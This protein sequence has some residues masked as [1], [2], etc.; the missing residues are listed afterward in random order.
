M[1]YPL[2]LRIQV[3]SLSAK[4]EAVDALHRSICLVRKKRFKFREH[5]TVFDGT[6]SRSPLCEI[7]LDPTQTHP[8][9]YSFTDPQGKKLGALA[10]AEAGHRPCYLV[11][12]ER[13]QIIYD[14]LPKSPRT[15]SLERFLAKVPVLR[16]FSTCLLRPAFSVRSPSQEEVFLL[17]KQAA[18]LES[19]YS[20][21]PLGT[22]VT[23]SLPEETRLLMA[24]LMTVFLEG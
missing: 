21:Q 5:V 1:N 6:P 7:Q 2:T 10:R 8:V 9:R 3:F 18:P 24:V 4:I 23:L 15:R 11:Q 16:L 17:R 20:L 13:G 14:I 22:T 12:D 19:R